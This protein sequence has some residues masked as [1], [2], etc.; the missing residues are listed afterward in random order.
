M[1]TRLATLPEEGWTRLSAGDGAK[2][3]RWSDGRWLPLAEPLEP[4][5]RRWRLVRRSLR[6][7]ADLTASVVYVPQPTRREAVVRVAGSRWT[8]ERSVAAATGEVGLAHDEVRRWTAWDS[9]SHARDGGVG[10]ADGHARRDEGGRPVHKTS[11]AAPGDEPAGGVQGPGW[12]RL[13][14][15]V[16]EWRR[17]FW[18]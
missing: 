9:A 3:P 1:N 17:L 16:A 4:G 2:G 18:R 5:W 13:P 15:S 7:P 8:I 10:P 14:W 6:A 11:A 12:S